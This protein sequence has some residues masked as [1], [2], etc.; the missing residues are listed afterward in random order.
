MQQQC[1]CNIV[2]RQLQWVSHCCSFSCCGARAL[3][4]VG[5]VV[6][7]P[8]LQRTGSIVMAQAHEFSCFAT[9]G[10]FLDQGLNPCLLHCFYTTEPG[11]KPWVI[12][13]EQKDQTER[14]G[15]RTTHGGWLYEE[16]ARCHPWSSNI[17]H[18]F[19]LGTE[20]HSSGTSFFQQQNPIV[21]GLPC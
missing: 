6:V 12:Y 10:I 21:Q 5:S 3:G 11:G 18:F 1:F 2:A 16:C 15:C 9:C 20:P 17:H 7:V 14:R 13:F 8:G 4:H 19:L